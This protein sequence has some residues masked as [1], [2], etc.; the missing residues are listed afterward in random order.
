MS[1]QHQQHTTER[2]QRFLRLLEPVR[3]RLS[4]F[5]WAMTRNRDEAED[6]AAEAIAAAWEG[7]DHLRDDAAFP[8][9]LLRITV[10]LHR[11]GRR[12]QK[13]WGLF[14]QE[15]AEQL[16]DQ[17]TPPDVAAEIRILYE[18]LAQLPERQRESVVLFE[19]ADLS[20]E[21]IQEIQ[22]GTLSGVK[23]RVTRGRERLTELMVGKPHNKQELTPV[24]NGILPE[25]G[26]TTVN[27]TTA[28]HR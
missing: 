16:R 10:R 25:K 28:I 21:E 8:G 22:G 4:R 27:I 24:K 11:R 12:R 20:L 18:A 7:L 9:W 3:P 23:S 15:Q 19:I 14:S 17:N 6:L 5:A 13:F 2:Q 1:S 26:N